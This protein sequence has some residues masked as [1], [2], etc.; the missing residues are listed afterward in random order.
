MMSN[1]DLIGLRSEDLSASEE[2]AQARLLRDLSTRE[3]HAA[4]RSLSVRLHHLPAPDGPSAESVLAA[5]AAPVPVSGLLR[6]GG[7]GVLALA[8]AAALVVMIQPSDE[9]R[10]KGVPPTSI[11]TVSLSAVAEG[12]AGARPLSEGALVQPGEWVVFQASVDASGEL[13]LYEDGVRVSLQQQPWRVGPGAHFAGPDSPVAYRPD[14]VGA[15]GL[16]R[17]TLELCAG[18][19][20]E[21]SSCHTDTLTLR[22][23]GE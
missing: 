17:Y 12:P 8:A 7:G 1:D 23:A 20:G 2:A 3:E 13:R 15:G 10:N 18:Q 4:M 6:W 22:W 19:P 21:R 14:A 16:R 11:V 9:Q 5:A